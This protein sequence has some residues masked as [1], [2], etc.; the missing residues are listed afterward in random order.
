VDSLLRL[1]W[2]NL[3]RNKRRTWLTVSAIAFVTVLM[4]FLITLQLGSY[5][6]MIDSSLRIFTGQ[7]QVQRDGY[8]EKRQI[9]TVIPDAQ[10]LAERLRANPALAKIG[11]AVRAQGFALA[12]SANRSFGVQVVGS[13]PEFEPKVST[14]PHL[15]KSGRWLNGLSVQ[16]AV[17]GS[18]L[19]QNLRIQVGDELTLLGAAMDG[20]VAATVLPVVGIFESGMRDLDRVT[21]EVPLATFQEVFGLGRNAHA[22]VFL[23]PDLKY[24]PALHAEVERQMTATPTLVVLD[25]ERLIPG[26]KQLTQA[27]WTTGWFMY[28]ALIAV[29][30]FSILNTFIMSVL[31]RTREFGIMLALGTTPLRIGSLV[32]IETA[33]L[34]LLGLGIGV[35]LGLVIAAI[36]SVVGFTYPGLKELMG[37][38]G[39]PGL[40][41]PKLSA[42]SVLLGPAVILTFILVAALYP[43]LRIRKLEAVEAI[44]AI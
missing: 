30:T 27:D 16:E 26:L 39:L 2:R 3:W 13:E 19:A 32:F 42:T 38:Y 21:V 18:A 15:I 33:F 23:A 28:I 37:Q 29:V 35:A 17:L 43:A 31:E 20:S 14:I 24:L 5:D 9:R 36:L 1:A 12:S 8:L 34:A 44:H 40:I 4:V 10:A 6:L 41:Y 7:M 11:V 25:W 22:I